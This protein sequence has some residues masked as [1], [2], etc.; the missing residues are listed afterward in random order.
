MQRYGTYKILHSVFWEKNEP[1]YTGAQ[2]V[3]GIF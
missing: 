2:V 1:I 3:P